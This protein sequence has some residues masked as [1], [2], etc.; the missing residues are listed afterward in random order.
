VNIHIDFFSYLELE[1]IGIGAFTPLNGFMKEEDF[2]SVVENMRLT[3]GKLFPL[4]VLLPIKAEVFQNIV[5]DSEVNLIFNKINV[6]ILKIESK[7]KINFKNHIVKLFGT[8]D[9][10]HPGY[11]MLNSLGKFFVG[12]K[13]KFLNKVNNNLSKYEL[14]PEVVKK[15]I[16][17]RN[18]QYVA[19]FQTRNVP[20]R[21]HEYILELALK[22]MDGLFVQ[23][24]IGRKRLGD[25]TPEAVMTSYKLLQS[26]FFPPNKII[27]GALTTSMRYAGPREAV[28]HALIRKNY[29]CTHF[30]VGRDHAGVGNYY[31][32]YEAQSL[33]IKF[34]DELG[35]N[36]IKV[37]GPFYCNKCERIN[38][39]TYCQHPE[40]RIPVSGTKIRNSL[41]N[42]KKINS[43]FMR[44]EIV[45][46]L[47]NIEIFI[48]EDTND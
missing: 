35:I 21:A 32:E 27:L 30:L 9:I 17:N 34:E 45:K 31:G 43:R 5:L 19:G 14:V 29:G 12:G 48:K 22:D 11:T 44:P 10:E 25:F 46:S 13:I 20:H 40:D 26:N 4:P 42:G 33:C 2:Y 1:K 18:M 3:S 38:I 41:I 6:G 16:K 23:P 15:E 8:E 36:I 37:R 39:D 47:N 24:L 7:Y 28:F